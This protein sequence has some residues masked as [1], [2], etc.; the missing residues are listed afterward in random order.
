MNE[1]FCQI[2][3]FVQTNVQTIWHSDLSNGKDSNHLNL[4]QICIL[5]VLIW[6]ML[7]MFFTEITK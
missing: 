1:V 2:P 7:S 5:I 6:F 4:D 3:F